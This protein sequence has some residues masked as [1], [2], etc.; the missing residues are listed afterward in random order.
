[1]DGRLGD[2][3]ALGD[4]LGGEH[5]PIP[6][7]LA[8]ARQVV[9]SSDEVNLLQIERLTVP[10]L[11]ASFVE[12]ISDLTIAISVKQAINLS[13]EFGLEFADLSDR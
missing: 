5:S 11:N 2:V 12:D 6:Q 13:N 10:C 7:S 3:E 4:F 8:P 9:G 1:M